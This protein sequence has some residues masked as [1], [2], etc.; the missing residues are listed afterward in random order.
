M[1]VLHVITDLDIGG[2]EM[3]LYRLLAVSG[4]SIDHEAVISMMRAGVLRESIEGLGVPV[5]SLDLSRG[6]PGPGSAARAWSVFRGLSGDLLQGWMY[7]GNI[8]ATLGARIVKG[9]QPVIWN[10]RHSLHDIKKEK[11]LTAGLI[12]LGAR[13]SGMPGA[14]IYNSEVSARQHEAI[15]YAR[16]RRKVIPNGVDCDEYKP[17]PERRAAMRQAIGCSETVT[18]VG[19]IA[20]N[21]PMKN[22]EGLLRAVSKLTPGHPDLHLLI[23]GRG[24]DWQNQDLAA[25]VQELGLAG[26]V[27]LLGERR[28]VADVMPALDILVLPSSWGEGFPNVVAEAMASGVPCVVTDIGD[29]AMV[30]GDHGIVVAADD[31]EALRSG[32]H[33]LIDIE[34][35]RRRALGAAGRKRIRERFSI[36]EVGRCYSSVYEEALMCLH[37]KASFT[38]NP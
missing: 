14:I 7:H 32:V 20:R 21:H 16:A 28:D 30:V 8:A 29:S 38:L 19:M 25:K 37:P 10:I 31:D 9:R 17:C 36:E 6:L 12:R 24:H 18:L 23:A 1:R 5:R 27:S 22:A 35:D 4:P 15:G 34:A 33:H 11:R 3:S 2:A 26:R 13:L